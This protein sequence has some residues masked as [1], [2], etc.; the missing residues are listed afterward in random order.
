MN[1]TLFELAFQP[2]IWY[3]LSTFAGLGKTVKQAV[4][5]LSGRLESGWVAWVSKCGQMVAELEDCLGR[6]RPASTAR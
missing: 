1:F 6:V 4:V 5:S 2:P 3:P